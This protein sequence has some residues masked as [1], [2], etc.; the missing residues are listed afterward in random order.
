M[1]VGSHF[2]DEET[3]RH[4][5][6]EELTLVTQEDVCELGLEPSPFGCRIH[7]IYHRVVWPL[8]FGFFCF[9]LH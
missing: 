3:V 1:A 6:V 5:H 8:T 9:Q 4:S 7:T 2:I